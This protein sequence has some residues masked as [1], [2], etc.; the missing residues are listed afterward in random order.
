MSIQLLDENTIN[1]ISAGEVVER[2][3]N[4]VKELVENA[5]DAGASSV[6]VEIE[7]AGKKLIS[8]TDNGC[9]M[10]RADLE[11]SIYRHTTSKISKFEDIAN[12]SSLGFRG[13]ALASISAVSM[14]T[15]KTQTKDSSSGWQLSVD[16]EK[17][18]EIQPWAGSVGTTVEVRNLFFNTPVREKFLKSDTTEK[19]KILSCLDEI[20]LVRNDINL[21]II[22]DG[23]VVADYQKTD[24][25]LKRVEEVLG[26]DISGK[27]K[28][29]SYGH[30]TMDID[31]FITTRN[32]S[33]AQKNVWYLF[34]NGRCVNYPKWLI[35]AVNQACKSAIPV[36]RYP[37]IILFLKTSPSD[38]DINIHPTKREIKFAYENQMYDL[39]Y[40]FIKSSLESDSPISIMESNDI[41]TENTEI[42]LPHEEKKSFSSFGGRSF[43]SSKSYSGYSGSSYVPS[44]KVSINDYKK[45]Y[46]HSE[47]KNIELNESVSEFK[48]TELIKN[49][50]SFKFVGQI[51]ETYLLVEKEDTFYIIDQHAA[52]ERVRYEMFLGQLE[53]NSLKIQQLL[54]PDIFELAKS[55]AVILKNYLELFNKLG[56]TVEEF[57]DN[58]FRLTSYPALLGY[59]INFIEIID[60]LVEFLQD[61]KTADVEQIQEKIIRASCRTSIKAGDKVQEVQAKA[62]LKEL[63]ACKMPWTCPHG[64]PTVYKLTLSE[65]EKF[66]KRI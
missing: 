49:D 6:Q 10:D 1:K 42:S 15:I 13:E 16:G 12:I 5:L 33:L 36:G 53:Q 20:A 11:K 61:E 2:P 25:K 54:I 40:S 64:R 18:P 26:K 59:N 31:G 24:S 34:V 23:K 39:F 63:F 22:S 65:I 8:V 30:P 9:G 35:H 29:I 60:I 17:S 62:L 14:L 58:S 57:G 55:K 50:N 46:E 28:H 41:V 4:V 43:G 44:P 19:S 7:K 56:F 52:Q 3:L 21:R 38:I 47:N 45:L 48:Q 32:N 66:F 51:F 37:G 27:L